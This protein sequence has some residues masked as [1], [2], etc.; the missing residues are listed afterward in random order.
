VIIQVI[1]LLSEMI[2]RVNKGEQ[3]KTLKILSIVLSIVCWVGYALFIVITT[4]HTFFKRDEYIY[5]ATVA[6]FV[7]YFVLYSVM[8]LLQGIK[9][10]NKVLKIA[11]I[12]VIVCSMALLIGALSVDTQ[13]EAWDSVEIGFPLI[14]ALSIIALVPFLKEVELMKILKIL[15][16]AVLVVYPIYNFLPSFKMND[17]YLFLWDDGLFRVILVFN[18]AYLFFYIFYTVICFLQGIKTKNKVLIIASIIGCIVAAHGIFRDIYLNAL[19]IVIP[20][21]IILSIIALVLSLKALKQ[22]IN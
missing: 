17:D 6:V 15:S 12:I 9:T 16:I 4:E 1:P 21:A 19:A 8:C 13:K 14:L 18:L 7:V 2:D 5:G 10:K 22:K 20:F 3:M 11:S